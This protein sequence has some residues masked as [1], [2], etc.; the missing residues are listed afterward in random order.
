MRTRLVLWSKNENNER[1]LL[2]LSLDEHKG[3]IDV[4]KLPEGIVNDELEDALMESWR[5]GEEISFPE[6]YTPV[7]TQISV[8]ESILPEG[9]TAEDENLLKR[10]QAEWNFLVLSTKV[11]DNYRGKLEELKE[12]VASLT[13]FDS[14]VWESLRSFWSKVQG[15]VRER[16]LFKDHAD[17]IRKET[18]ELFNKMK[19]LRS[20]WNEAFKARSKE[21]YEKLLQE[22]KEVE[23]KIETNTRLKKLFDELKALQRKMREME[24]T[25]SHRN[26]IWDRID[27]AFKAVRRKHFGDEA[28]DVSPLQRLERRYNGLIAAIERM[29]NSIERERNDLEFQKRKIGRADNQLEA[30]LR[31]AK[32]AMIEER[33]HSKEEKLRDM[34]KTKEELEK[35][36]EKLIAREEKRKQREE[37]ARKKK[38]AE[39]AARKKIEEEVKRNKEILEAA[40]PANKSDQTAEEEKASEKTGDAQATEKSTEEPKDEG[41]LLQAVGTLLGE[42]LTD[43]VDTAKAIAEV[44]SDKIEDTVEDLLGK[45]EEEE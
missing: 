3:D 8:T 39:E 26:R 2:A 1:Y 20:K 15:Q 22:I 4:W 36:R 23:D 16:T 32:V 13:D 12:K 40:G 6:G 33:L 30:Q 43:V 14:E 31:Q 24:F 19:E 21:N 29:E 37:M 27:K 9:L 41:S 10:V 7:K 44:V 38:E 42:S 18:D 34:L 25:K 45:K 28:E 17:E 35:R 5:K 11:Y